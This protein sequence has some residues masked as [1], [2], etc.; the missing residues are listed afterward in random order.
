MGGR[1]KTS[2]ALSYS[3]FNSKFEDS[4]IAINAPYTIVGKSKNDL[5]PIV[6]EMG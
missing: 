2:L 5:G 6:E 4:N 1:N 3:S